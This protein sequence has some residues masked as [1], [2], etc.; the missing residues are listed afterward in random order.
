[1]SEPDPP[2]VPAE[3]AAARDPGSFAGPFFEG[4]RVLIVDD[5]RRSQLVKLKASGVASTHDGALD[6]DDIIGAEPG[7]RIMTRKGKMFWVI[8]PSLGEVIAAMPRGAQVIYPKDLGQIL[9]SADIRPSQRVLESGVGSGALSMTLLNVG[10]RVQGYELREDFANRA[11]N[12]VEEYLPLEAQQRYHVELRDIY[13]GIDGGPYDRVLLD[14]PEPW[15]VLEHLWG[16]LV[17]AGIVLAYQTSV[18]QLETFRAALAK[19]GFILAETVE[20][21]LRSWYHSRSALRPDHRMVA[22]TGF[23]TWARLGPAAGWQPDPDDQLA[24]EPSEKGANAS[25]LNNP[26]A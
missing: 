3:M 14:L 4:E 6:H 11:R 20:V 1:M 5:R 26:I 12:N 9:M 22:H 18:G 21:L 25:D 23:L 13:E 10:A 15:R 2:W 16:N 19:E 8:R 24:P 17:P 7:S